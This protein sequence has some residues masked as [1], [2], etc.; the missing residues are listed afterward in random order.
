MCLCV[1]VC[2][3]ACMCVC[4]LTQYPNKNVALVASDILHLLISYVDHLQ[5]FP[6]D[7]PKKIVEVRHHTHR[8][9]YIPE[10]VLPTSQRHSS[11]PMCLMGA[12]RFASVQKWYK[13]VHF[14]DFHVK[15]NW[16]DAVRAFA[17]LCSQQNVD[18][19]VET[20]SGVDRQ[21]YKWHWSRPLFLYLLLRF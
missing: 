20:G 11:F 2:V 6:P 14:Q 13:T 9:V 7:T 17:S 19:R 5:D 21:M 3:C 1:C 10:T 12:T 18:T 16:N 4:F 8:H 15:F